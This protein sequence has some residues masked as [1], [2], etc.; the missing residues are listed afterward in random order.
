MQHRYQFESQ[1]A[2]TDEAILAAPSIE[3]RKPPAESAGILIPT[4][5]RLLTKQL[6]RIGADKI[7]CLNR[8]NG[9]P[10]NRSGKRGRKMLFAV[11]DLRP[12]R[13]FLRGIERQAAVRV[14]LFPLSTHESRP[15]DALWCGPRQK[16][17]GAASPMK[18][19]LQRSRGSIAR[20]DHNC[21]LEQP[22]INCRRLVQNG[23][24]VCAHICVIRR[25][26][27]AF[28]V[29]NETGVYAQQTRHFRRRCRL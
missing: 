1:A 2:R 26:M 20:C 8:H 5:A 3:I 15:I 9:Q 28:S 19:C 7:V 13:Q 24:W 6:W 17:L 23:P 27:H 14:A 29:G 25:S 18:L 10:A 4:C 12:H 11:H 22:R 21:A 16:P